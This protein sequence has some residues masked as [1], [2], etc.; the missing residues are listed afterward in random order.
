MLYKPTDVE[1]NLPTSLLPLCLPRTHPFLANPNMGNRSATPIAQPQDPS[2]TLFSHHIIPSKVEILPSTFIHANENRFDQMYKLGGLL[3][4]GTHG[5]VR[6]CIHRDTRQVRAVKIFNRQVV[7]IEEEDITQELTLMKSIDHPNIVRVF[8]YFVDPRYVF[9]VMEH[10]QGGQ[11]QGR[12]TTQLQF[13]ERQ[14]A[15]IMR[16]LFSAV[17]YMQDLRIVHRGISPEKILLE[18]KSEDVNIKL[19]DFGGS[20]RK[21]GALSEDEYRSIHYV[22]PELLTGDSEDLCDLWSCGVIMFVLLSGKVPFE[23]NSEAQIREKVIEGQFTT[24]GGLWNSVSNEAKNLIAAILQ[25]TAKRINPTEA[26]HHPWFARFNFD[27]HVPQDFVRTVL[28]N[29]LRFHFSTKLQLAALTFI[30]TQLLSLQDTKDL[31]EV[32]RLMDKNGD[33]RI[34][35][36]ELVEVYRETMPPS[37]AE[38]AVNHI[39]ARADTDGSGFMDYSEFL[40]ASIDIKTLLTEKLLAEVFSVFDRDGNGTITSQEIM[41]V[42]MGNT[43]EGGE[44]VWRE[45]V[46][47]VDRNGDGVVDIKEFREILLAKI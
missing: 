24:A 1:I 45:V 23:G 41:S 10:C 28:A 34:S 20:V 25:P 3:G 36:T 11:L 18:E 32:F 12:I 2:L 26:L 19:I 15:L 47:E 17:V 21:K 7:H 22:A 31:R 5:E 46:Q 13:T 27:V 8:E 14:V 16:Q 33:G 39:M 6:K 42:L 37:E 44:E 29:V 43:I 38:K 9:V 40:R 35:K 30:T 4:E